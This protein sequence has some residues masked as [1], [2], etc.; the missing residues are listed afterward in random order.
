MT[1]KV[2]S[3]ILSSPVLLAPMSGISDAPFRQLVA[4]FGAG[5]VFSEMIA[6]QAMIRSTRESLGK[7]RGPQPGDNTGGH[8]CGGAGMPWA[9][10]L[11]GNEPEVMAEAARAVVDQGARLVDINMGCPVKKVTRGLAGSAL[12]RDLDLARRIL[13]A[14]TA[15]VSVPVTLKMRLGWDD[16]QRNAPALAAIAQDCG[17]AMLTVH[18]RTRCQL[19]GGQADWAAVASVKA[20]VSIPVVVNGDIATPEQALR[21]LS[22]SGADAVMVG[23]GACGRPWALS[24]I[25]DVLSGRRPAP[26]PSPRARLDLLL[27]HY[28]AML[29]HYGTARGVRIARK[30]LAWWLRDF[31]AGEAVARQANSLDEP[32]AVMALLRRIAPR[33]EER[34]AA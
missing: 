9:V 2:G 20:A 23:R 10:Q 12:M 21:A 3:F 8:A 13:A 15:A 26:E 6:S 27:G 18:G 4:G 1:I 31:P 14:V 29:G 11:A 30:H 34:F 17:I 5:L 32:G 7:A 16:G 24:R 25:A 19:F 22:A 33:A 28:E